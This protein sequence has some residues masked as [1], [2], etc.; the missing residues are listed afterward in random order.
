MFEVLS[1][2]CQNIRPI[3]KGVKDSAY[4]QNLGGEKKS[5]L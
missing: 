1:C 3:T 5:P 2:S 4:L